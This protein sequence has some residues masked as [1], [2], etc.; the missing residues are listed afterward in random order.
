MSAVGR[1]IKWGPLD[2]PQPWRTIVGVVADV[3]QTGLAEEQTLSAI[4]MPAAQLDTG[5]AVSRVRGQ[6]YVMRTTGD[7]GAAMTAVRRTVK[8]FDGLM[9]MPAITPMDELL[10]ST[11]ADRRFNLFLLAG[12]AAV[13]LSLAAVGVYG[14]IAYSVAHRTR[15]LGIRL[16]LGALPR[17]VL[18]LV[19]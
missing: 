19:I 2:S 6:N 16:A 3:K 9:P 5:P 13:A 17:D 7:P 8:D 14:L 10:S 4:Y 15:E 1:R 11:I 12:F 18:F